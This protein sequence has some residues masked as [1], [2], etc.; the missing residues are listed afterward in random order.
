MSGAPQFPI[1]SYVGAQPLRPGGAAHKAG[2]SLEQ[3]IEALERGALG[4]PGP[5]VVDGC[6]ITSDIASQG[7]AKW[8][9]TGQVSGGYD[10]STADVAGAGDKL[11]ITVTG[12]NATPM[13][14]M[15]SVH[16][17]SSSG[18]LTV[19]RAA[20]RDGAGGTGTVYDNALFTQHAAGYGGDL[21]LFGAVPAFSG[22]KTFYLNISSTGAGLTAYG[23]VRPT[24]LRAI[25][26]PGF[27]A[28]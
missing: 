25:W 4:R 18:A 28:S 19:N 17:G 9:P 24:T 1:P 13:F 12:N 22:S 3:R 21:I 8:V 7:R 11:S 10:E 16:T 27:E 6:T 26:A 23:T 2:L 14:V 5:G 15:A 20:I